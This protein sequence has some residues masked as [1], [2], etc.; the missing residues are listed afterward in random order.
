MFPAFQVGAVTWFW[1]SVVP[2]K[3]GEKTSKIQRFEW[4]IPRGTFKSSGTQM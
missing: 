3:F 4:E 1:D 2:N